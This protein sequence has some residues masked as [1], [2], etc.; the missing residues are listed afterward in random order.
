MSDRFRVSSFL[1]RQ[2]QEQNISPSMVLR[3]AGLPLGLFQQDKILVTTEELFSLWRAIGETSNEPAV[4]LKLGAEWQAER[5]DP[6]TIAALHSRSF[7]DGL[8]RLA[9]YKQLV[10]PEQI[11]LH[12]GK[13]E[14]AV[15]FVFLLGRKAEPTVLVD[16]CLSRILAV[17]RRGTGGPLTPLGLELSRQ[18]EHRELLET[19]FGC[20]VRFEATR[21]ALIFRA[22]D[23]DRPF[24]THNA[25][26]LA[27]LC[28]QLDSQLDSRMAHRSTSDQVKAT[29]KGLLAGRRP[30]LRDVARE[31]NVSS[32]TLQRRLTESGATFKQLLGETRRELAHYY[33]HYSSFELNETAYLLGYED[34]TSFFRAFQ[35]W[36]GTSPN[37]WRIRSAC[38][39]EAVSETLES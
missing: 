20:R 32:R 19:H 31:L 4:G 15:E 5:Y 30:S 28:P 10:C 2:L 17:G 18:P 12:T 24:M 25:E 8:R 37:R 38:E 13:G 7:G 6:G 22:T 34:P 9:R 3:R 21:N 14:S 23:L 16:A 26:L 35:L 11:R 27:V 33:L 36:E 1:A 29:L 39:S